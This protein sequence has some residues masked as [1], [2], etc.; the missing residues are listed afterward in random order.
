MR[1]DKLLANLQYGSRKEVGCLIAKGRVA[2][3]AKTVIDPAVHIDPQSDVV[4]VDGEL[5][6]YEESIVLMLNKPAGVISSTDEPGDITAIELLKPPFNRFRFQ[7]AGRLDRDATGLLLLSTNGE[8]THRIITPKKEIRKQYLVYLETPLDDHAKRELEAG[9]SIP[10]A[11][12]KEYRTRPAEVAIL[13][14]GVCQVTI[15]EGKYHQVKLMLRAVGNRV[16]VLKRTAIG[17]LELDPALAPGE[18]RKLS[19][20]EIARIFGKD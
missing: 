19:E 3:N 11:D 16:T 7:I 4:T 12:G 17:G 14:P 13:A 1:L 15:C 10:T 20:A 18:Y 5:V 6:Y 9:V 2:V 8:L